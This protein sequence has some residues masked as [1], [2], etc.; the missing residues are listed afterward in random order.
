MVGWVR[1]GRRGVSKEGWL[2]GWRRAAALL[3]LAAL[4]A[5]SR[6]G[7]KWYGSP[8]PACITRCRAPPPPLHPVQAARLL[9]AA[10]LGCAGHRHQGRARA[11]AGGA[12]GLG[13]RVTSLLAGRAN[14]PMTLTRARAQARA[15]T[16]PLTDLQH[17]CKPLTAAPRPVASC[18]DGCECA[19]ARDV[20]LQHS[21]CRAF[22]RASSFLSASSCSQSLVLTHQGMLA[23][24]RGGLYAHFACGSAAAASQAASSAA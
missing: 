21:R 23:C 9:C 13:G 24:W 18:D 2:A 15:P 22:F 12:A 7:L 17:A 14:A 5:R 3:A 1:G 8:T 20:R 19:F 10:R 11:Q 4:L 6:A 16:D